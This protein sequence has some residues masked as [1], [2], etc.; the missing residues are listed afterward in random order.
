MERIIAARIELGQQKTPANVI[1]RNVAA[2]VSV[3]HCNQTGQAFDLFFCKQPDEVRVR[4]YT[5][6]NE[7]CKTVEQGSLQR[8]DHH[9]AKTGV[10]FVGDEQ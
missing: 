9:R 7:I 2:G 8:R 1:G 10:R 4:H 6:F 3:M 5:Q